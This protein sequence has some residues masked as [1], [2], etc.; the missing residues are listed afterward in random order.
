L[1][2]NFKKNIRKN[3]NNYQKNISEI[4][5]MCGLDFNYSMIRAYNKVS[6]VFQKH[7]KYMLHKLQDFVI[8]CEK[9]GKTRYQNCLDKGMS[10]KQIFSIFMKACVNW[11][12]IPV[13]AEREDDWR[14]YLLTL[15][16]WMR[17]VDQR[18]AKMGKEFKNKV[19]MLRVARDTFPE[20]TYR[21]LRVIGH[22]PSELK[23][24]LLGDG[25]DS[26]N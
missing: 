5:E 9:N 15:P 26:E 7:R 1:I 24:Y 2:K 21:E 12:V 25:N 20:T 23:D 6:S 19:D 11:D 22:K 16:A 18:I 17:M 10:E 8:L 3:P 4:M 14:Y 13:Y